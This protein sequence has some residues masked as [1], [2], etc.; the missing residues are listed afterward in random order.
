MVA[1][2]GG[3]VIDTAKFLAALAGS[4]YAK[5]ADIV[6]RPERIGPT[7]APLVAVPTTLGSGSECSPAAGLHDGPTGAVVGTRSPLLVPRIAICDPD[8]ARTL[9]RHLIAATGV[10]ALSHCL[11]GFLAVPAHPVLDALALDGVA[12]ARRAVAAAA[13]GEGEAREALMA[14]AFMGGAAIHKGLGPA[15][16][17]ALTCGDQDLHHG[18]LIAAALPL[19][20]ALMLPHVPPEDA[21]RAAAAL[22]VR[23][24]ADIPDSLRALNDALGLANSF[25]ALGFRADSLDLLAD[26]AATSHFNRTSAYVPTRAEYLDVLEALMV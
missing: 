17:V 10:D 13:E 19:T 7:V 22:G 1:L 26:K 8:L 2:G 9:P 3:S 23:D 4:Q 16:T 18:M 24:P 14:A 5:A 25:K 21:S 20:I 12:R 15:H 6:G 11:E